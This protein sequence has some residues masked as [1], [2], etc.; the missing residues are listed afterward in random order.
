M[1]DLVQAIQNAGNLHL[2]LN[3][4]AFWLLGITGTAAEEFAVQQGVELVT[5]DPL[6]WHPSTCRAAPKVA[7]KARRGRSC[8]RCSSWVSGHSCTAMTR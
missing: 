6:F 3:F 7:G 4:S 2:Q 8:W 1:S 5:G